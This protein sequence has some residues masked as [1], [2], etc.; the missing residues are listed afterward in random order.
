M[1]NGWACNAETK[2]PADFVV[3]FDHS[4]DG[5]KIPVLLTNLDKERKDVSKVLGIKNI[6]KY[7]FH[8]HLPFKGKILFPEMYAVDLKTKTLFRLEKI[9]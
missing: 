1:I 5:K 2:K 4:L 8:H 6:N 7:G 9:D 3:L